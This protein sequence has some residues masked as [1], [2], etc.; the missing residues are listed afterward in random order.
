MT[1]PV[2]PIISLTEGQDELGRFQVLMVNGSSQV[3]RWIPAGSFLMGSP[4]AGPGRWVDEVQRQVEIPGGYWL[5]DTACTQAFYEA[6]MGE[7]PSY[8]RVADCPV[9]CVS[10]NGAQAFIL[11]LNALAP[12]LDL[13]LPSEAEWEYACRAG[14]TTAYSFGDGITNEQVNFDSDGAVPVKSLPANAWGLHEMHG[15]VWEWCGDE[16]VP[17]RRMLRGGCWIRHGGYCCSAYCL[18]Y[19]PGDRSSFIGFRLARG[20]C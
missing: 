11:K 3:F 9:E 20:A 6:V 14:T 10:W 19:A 8:S 12:S 17:G 2:A 1:T 15:N 18:A 7:N 5:A 16:F 4:E 13:R